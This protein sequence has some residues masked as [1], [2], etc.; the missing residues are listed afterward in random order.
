MNKGDG[1]GTMVCSIITPMKPESWS[2]ALI[3]S[4]IHCVISGTTNTFEIFVGV[5]SID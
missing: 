2:W 1:M 4:I 5:H 3:N